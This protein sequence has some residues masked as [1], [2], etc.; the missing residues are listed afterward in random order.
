MARPKNFPN[1]IKQRRTKALENLEW[2]LE[3]VKKLESDKDATTAEKKADKENKERRI[4]MMT[5]E[6]RVLKERISKD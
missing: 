6:I 5:A 1:R 3:K 2:R 4:E